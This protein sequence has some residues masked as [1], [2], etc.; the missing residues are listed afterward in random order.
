MPVSRV[1]EIASGNGHLERIGSS[2]ERIPV[3]YDLHVTQRMIPVQGSADVPGMKSITG[4]IRTPHDANGIA[5][6]YASGP[7]ERFTLYLADNRKLDLFI[8][9]GNGSIAASGSFYE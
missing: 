3:T 2:S 4:A 6:L 1:L 7:R 5:S 9:S 8:A